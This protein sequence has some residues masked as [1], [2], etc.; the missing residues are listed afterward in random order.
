MIGS[1]VISFMASSVTFCI[2]IG[3]SFT[4]EGWGDNKAGLAGADTRLLVVSAILM[5]IAIVVFWIGMHGL[6][7]PVSK[8][9]RK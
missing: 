1:S 2:A 8:D 4:D 5:A 6:S 3:A 9:T 7:N